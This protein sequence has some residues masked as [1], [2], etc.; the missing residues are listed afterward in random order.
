MRDLRVDYSYFGTSSYT[1]QSRLAETLL[2]MNTGA[3][4]M[5]QDRHSY[6]TLA[7]ATAG[8]C[9]HTCEQKIAISPALSRQPRE[10]RVDKTKRRQ[11]KL[12]A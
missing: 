7:L 9:F 4:A 10:V 11:G 6:A 5:E 8:L 12:T 3:A 1:L 2:S